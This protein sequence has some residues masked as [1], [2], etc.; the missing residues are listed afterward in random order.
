M[1]IHNPD[2]V[3]H[4]IISTVA[5]K[6]K[7]YIH[8]YIYIYIYIYIHTR[9]QRIVSTFKNSLKEESKKFRVVESRKRE[10]ERSKKK[11]KR[12]TG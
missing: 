6:K 2:E 5:V 7:I 10:D 9:P 11:K 1:C 4:S 12:K 3:E 8:I